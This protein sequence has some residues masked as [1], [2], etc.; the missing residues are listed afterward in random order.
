MTS[1]KILKK[2]LSQPGTT[3][4]NNNNKKKQ[5]ENLKYSN[6]SPTST[7]QAPVICRSPHR[8]MSIY[9][10][11]SKFCSGTGQAWRSEVLNNHRTREV[12][13]HPELMFPRLRGCVLPSLMNIQPRLLN[14]DPLAEEQNNLL[15]IL[16][17]TLRLLQAF[18]DVLGLNYFLGHAARF[19]FCSL[20]CIL[21]MQIKC[22]FFSVTRA[23]IQF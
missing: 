16:F 10:L 1:L 22:K 5:Q 23:V 2:K 21:R 17:I 19:F 20:I 12:V 4:F 15:T 18:L 9:G 7:L 11:K 14:N 6:K 3:P 13:I 8:E